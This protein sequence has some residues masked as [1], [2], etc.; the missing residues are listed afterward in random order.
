MLRVR[1]YS[2]TSKLTWMNMLVSGAGLLLAGAAFLGYEL[3]TVRRIVFQDKPTGTVVIR[4]DL[5]EL[6]HRLIQ[7]GVLGLLVL[8]ASLL[9]VV[10]LSSVLRRIIAEP[11][12]SLASTAKVFSR[13]KDY[14]I[15]TAAS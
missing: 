14:S 13:E 10:M 9:T 2:I 3:V 11:I 12:A 6:K 4:S 1:D 5:E 8:A 7:F 15:R